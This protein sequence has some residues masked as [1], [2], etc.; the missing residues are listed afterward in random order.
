MPNSQSRNRQGGYIAAATGGTIGAAI[1]TTLAVRMLEYLPPVVPDAG[2][3]AYADN[4]ALPALVRA[5]VIVF[6]GLWSGE[7]IG[8]WLGLRLGGYPYAKQTAFRLIGLTPC[9]LIASAFLIS[10]LLPL[11]NPGELVLLLG[12]LLLVALPVAVRYSINQVHRS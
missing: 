5:S 6:G 7:V 11:V 2:Q 1:I 9:W 8:C 4:G 10:H 3:D 12:F